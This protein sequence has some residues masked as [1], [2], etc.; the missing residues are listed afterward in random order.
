[1][2][3]PAEGDGPSML[4]TADR[5]HLPCGRLLRRRCGADRRGHE[6][7]LVRA[8]IGQRAIEK[9]SDE[10][11]HGPSFVSVWVPHDPHSREILCRLRVVSRHGE[12]SSGR[13]SLSRGL[14]SSSDATK[15][16]EKYPHLPPSKPSSVQRASDSA[17]RAAGAAI[18]PALVASVLSRRPEEEPEV[19]E[20]RA[21]AEE[22][23]DDE[24]GPH[25]SSVPMWCSRKTSY[26]GQRGRA[27]HGRGVR[28]ASRRARAASPPRR[29]TR[30]TSPGR[31]SCRST[32]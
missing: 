31:W 4:R 2:S 15:P 21:E 30:R 22:H 11:A 25:A 27:G 19:D 16:D 26:D 9:T 14:A 18:P 20:D 23:G 3:L 1:M 13:N 29:C 5:R 7:V 6:E 28:P 8:R 32:G 17:G 12:R 24:R 10:C